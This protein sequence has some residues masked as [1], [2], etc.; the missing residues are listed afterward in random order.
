MAVGSAC[1]LLFLSSLSSFSL[2]SPFL[3][4]RYLLP[5]LLLSSAA[6]AAAMA[7]SIPCRPR[8]PLLPPS[9][10]LSNHRCPQHWSLPSCHSPRRRHPRNLGVYVRCSHSCSK[11]RRSF[12]LLLPHTAAVEHCRRRILGQ[13]R[14]YLSEFEVARKMKRL[15]RCHPSLGAS[16]WP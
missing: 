9:P 16:F 1:Q 5:H 8:E 3:Y 7:G 4:S 15:R 10:P 12:G 2:F 6:T 11:C 14:P 13:R